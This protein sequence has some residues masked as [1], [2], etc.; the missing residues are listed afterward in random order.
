MGVS[1]E[2]DWTLLKLKMLPS[3]LIILEIGELFR[4][5]KPGMYNRKVIILMR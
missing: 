1:K 5:V 4:K 2:G 3:I